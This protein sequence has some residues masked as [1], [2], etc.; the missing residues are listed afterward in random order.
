MLNCMLYVSNNVHKVI[1]IEVEALLCLN[2]GLLVFYSN[3]LASWFIINH[4]ETSIAVLDYKKYIQ[5][6]FF[7]FAIMFSCCASVNT[8]HCLYYIVD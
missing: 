6:F 5:Y 8:S 1:N 4:M 7:S 3:D 2:L